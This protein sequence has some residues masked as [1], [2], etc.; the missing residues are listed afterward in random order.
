M[1]EKIISP[2]RRL[3]YGEQKIMETLG[4]MTRARLILI[5]AAAVFAAALLFAGGQ[6]GDVAGISLRAF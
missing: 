1:G 6:Y 3:V 2:K 4:I 5:V